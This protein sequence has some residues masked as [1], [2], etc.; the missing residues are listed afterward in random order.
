MKTKMEKIRNAYRN[1]P[2]LFSLL[3]A[4]AL[5]VTTVAI[6]FG[7]GLLPR[8]ARVYDNTS[9][10]LYTLHEET[11]KLLSELNC[12]VEI[13][14]VSESGIPDYGVTEVLLKSYAERSSHLKLTFSDPTS[15]FAEYGTLTEGCAVVRGEA[16][17][18]VVYS[19]DY[20]DVSEEAFNV[21]YNYYYY[22]TQQGYNLGSYA[23][24]MYSGYA[25]SLG[26]F[27]IARYQS[28]LTNAIRYVAS[29]DVTLIYTLTDHGE[30]LPD[31]YLYPELRLGNTELTFGKLS[32]GIPDGV[33]GVLINDPTSDLTAEDRNTLSEF[34]SGGGKLTLVTS[35]VN[36]KN[37][38]N[39]LSVCEEYGL[40]TDGGFLC[41][42]DKAYNY[43]EYQMV[44]VPTVNTEALGGYLRQEGV[45]PLITGGT[46]ITIADKEGITSVSLLTTSANAY[47]K[48]DAEK[49]GTTA[50]FNE[51]TDER[52]Q[53]SVAALA[54]NN[55]NGSSVLWI[56]TFTLGDSQYETA[57][58]R[59]N[60]PVFIAVLGTQYS[61][62]MPIEIEE[63]SL[64]LEPLSPPDAAFPVGMVIAIAL[65]CLIVTAGAVLVIK[66]RNRVYKPT[67]N[68][69]EGE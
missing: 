45:K 7:I 18:T 20:F 66:R 47:S 35:Y 69:D 55:A 22:L 36:I 6:Y 16:R 26:L 43:N 25:E 31:A 9:N 60:F 59:N 44:T 41:E 28:T 37:L 48:Q 21:S 19:S 63:I 13:I 67:L 3:L 49:E 34:L 5:I 32:D 15:L 2:A 56:P 38:P 40:T 14:M 54:K 68:D 27:D 12:D 64:S 61:S 24:F 46:G 1:A 57:S 53:Y 42:D 51:E 17:E 52:K 10:G 65:P 62:D 33:D 58:S 39:L 23:D 50:V 4:L 8:S 29:N 11:L 30:V